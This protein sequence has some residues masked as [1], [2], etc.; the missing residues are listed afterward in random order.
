MVGYYY[1][2]R[3]QIGNL[4]FLNAYKFYILDQMILSENTQKVG[5]VSFK[6]I[7]FCVCIFLLLSHQ[8]LMADV[9][10]PTL[11]EISVSEQRQV[12]VEIRAS[13][14][15]LLTGIN[16]KYK[17]TKEAPNALDYDVLRKL[18]SEKLS[19]EFDGF[20]ES[21]LEKIKLIDNQGNKIRLNISS[22]K[23]PEAGYT[24]VPRISVIN[25]QGNIAADV[26]SLRW[27]FPKSFA[28]NAVRLKQVN[29]I[30]QQYH[31]SDWQWLKNDE[32]SN[33]FSLTEIVAKQSLLDTIK[34]YI[35]L[36]FE[37]IFPKGLDHILFIL[38][39][40]LYTPAFKPLLWQ[41][42]MFTIAHTVTLGLATYGVISI[43]ANIVEPL[44]ALSI[45]YIAI[46]NIF[47]KNLNKSRLLLIFL[48][49]LL[50]GLGFAGVLTEFGLPQDDFMTALIS[51][52]LGVEIGQ[53]AIIIAAFLLVG[54]W[55][56]N[57]TW[58]RA[59]IT[60]PASLLIAVIAIYWFIQRLDLNF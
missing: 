5:G 20:K 49:G 40:F 39:L 3:A 33:A 23:I 32:M 26:K 19:V 21:F 31:W 58:Y 42:T 12:F 7:L 27:Y 1:Y 28:D 16:N 44:I 52:N 11:I 47:S 41:I 51:F 25:L 9:V 2:Y 4:V 46:E 35:V 43:S 38:G 37:H 10:K 50:H 56:K 13:I 8:R 6:Y 55:F 24:K 53:I 15:A 18:Q 36:G 54:L 14:E 17:N 22:V 48:F 30:E 45:A 60:T 34:T 59:S 29:E 57:K